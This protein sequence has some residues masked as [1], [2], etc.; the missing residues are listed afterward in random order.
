MQPVSPA[1]SCPAVAAV[2]SPDGRTIYAAGADGRLALLADD[3][4]A[5]LKLAD[6]FRSDVPITS[7]ALPSGAA[8]LACDR[9]QTE[10]CCSHAKGCQACQ[11]PTQ[12]S[13]RVSGEG[14]APKAPALSAGSCVCKQRRQ[15]AA[16][17][18]KGR[19][20]LLRLPLR[21]NVT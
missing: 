6:E 16:C 12:P 17:R 7:L 18:H 1:A 3:G 5:Q 13:L 14:D 21:V 11:R 8:F 10:S 2:A 15:G 20:R 4:G 19:R 9:I